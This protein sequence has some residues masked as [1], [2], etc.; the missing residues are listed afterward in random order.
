M[1]DKVYYYAIGDLLNGVATT[2]VPTGVI[3]VAFNIY[4]VVAGDTTDWVMTSN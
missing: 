3:N 1:Q 4:D 2:L